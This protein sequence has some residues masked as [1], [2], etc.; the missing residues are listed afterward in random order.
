MPDSK[1][2]ILFGHDVHLCCFCSL[3][4]SSDSVHNDGERHI[5][6]IMIFPDSLISKMYAWAEFQLENGMIQEQ[7]RCG[8]TGISAY[9]IVSLNNLLWSVYLNAE[10]I[11]TGFFKRCHFIWHKTYSNHSNRPLSFFIDIL[12]IYTHFDC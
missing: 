10:L 5:P 6:Y 3:N 4:L 1:N 8:C 7:L 9:P 2:C 12:Y 11:S